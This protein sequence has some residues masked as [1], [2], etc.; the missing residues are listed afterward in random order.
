MSNLD[1]SA[2][3]AQFID[4]F[5]NIKLP[6]MGAGGGFAPIG[7]EGYF[8]GTTAPVGWVLC[9]GSVL[10]I[11]DYPELATYYASHYGASNHFGGDGV[12]SFA[13][14]TKE[15]MP[16]N[17]D[18]VYGEQERVVGVWKETVDGVLKQKPV[19][20]K[21]VDF[22]A[23]PNATNKTIQ[24]GIANIDRIVEL[25][26]NA[27][28]GTST[29]QLPRAYYT[30]SYIVDLSAP[31]NAEIS[32]IT[33]VDYSTFNGTIFMQYTKTTD[34]WTLPTPGHS[35]DGNGVFCVK[36]TV[37]GDPNAHHYS[38]EEQVVGKWIDGRDVY[39]KT[40]TGLSIGVTTAATWQN[41]VAITNIDKVIDVKLYRGDMTAIVPFREI[42]V[43]DPATGYLACRGI[44]SDQ[45]R[46]ISDIIVQYTKTSGA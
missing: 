3:M 34:S 21:V 24:H 18:G 30:T 27:S 1:A 6:I 2:S 4:L 17:A 45:N 7:T 28:N 29:Y 12:T 33:N 40:F 42:T 8:E 10:N 36:A 23:L 44:L 32:I 15:G 20:L 37:A 22:G 38:T 14:P 41:L 31:T 16:E 9:D 19:Y 5:Q 11:A 13:V 39:E 25:S 46:T 35:A 26:G 43:P